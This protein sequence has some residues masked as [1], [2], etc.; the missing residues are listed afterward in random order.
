MAAVASIRFN[1]LINKFYKR[2]RDKGKPAK[3]AI[4]AAMHKLLFIIK[5]VLKRQTVW[6][7]NIS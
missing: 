5:A 3:V 4:V 2:L 6:T 7:E 1:H